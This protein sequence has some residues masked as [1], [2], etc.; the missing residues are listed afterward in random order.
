MQKRD[1]FIG[2]EGIR[3]GGRREVVVVQ[4][5]LRD[6]KVV[7]I[8]GK[9]TRSS[10]HITDVKRESSRGCKVRVCLRIGKLTVEEKE[11]RII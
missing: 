9:I 4:K 10:G 2:I 8:T 1:C 3:L 11:E 5:L 6:E 7:D